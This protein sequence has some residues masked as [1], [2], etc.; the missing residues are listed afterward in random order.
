MS[1]CGR[2]GLNM[3]N[4]IVHS[5]PMGDGKAAG[6]FAMSLQAKISN[7]EFSLAAMTKERDELKKDA[8]A[9]RNEKERQA[10]FDWPCSHPRNLYVGDSDGKYKCCECWAE[11][12]E[13][14]LLAIGGKT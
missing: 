14:R 7:L 8:I 9:W 2:C 11:E 10:S 13:N 6:S 12:A 4:E 5:C 3:S 1:I